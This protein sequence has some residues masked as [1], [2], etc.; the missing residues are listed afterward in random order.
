MTKDTWRLL[1]T[2]PAH[3]AWNMAVDEAI[4][5][6]IG[7]GNSLPTL[8]LYAW[9]P[10]CLS[11]GYAQPLSDVDLE[12]LHAR[13]WEL[14]RRPTGGRAVL[15]T[16]ELT[17]SVIAPLTEPRLAGSLLESYQRIATALVEGLHLLV[18]PVEIQPHA[19]GAASQ[20]SNPVC[21]EVPSAFEITVEGRKLI[22]SAQARRKEGVLQHGS[23]P[24]Y[25]DLR[26]ILEVLVYPDESVRRRAGVHLL[27]RATTVEAALGRRVSWDEAAQ[28]FVAAFT[29]VFNLELLSSEL[30]SR[31]K[32][33]A[34]KLVLQK[35]SHPE[36][37]RK[38]VHPDTQPDES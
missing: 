23:F 18:L 19:A 15:H 10:P 11:L 4:L 6:E 14:V 2:P 35:Y 8:R 37:V 17:Y 7:R 12:R 29:S 27:E 31:E 20:N 1:I 5:E 22:G 21:F 33:R 36:Q 28:V 3:G 34:D 9:D 24:L 38:G 32:E 30:T 16:D 13:G 25:G 26:R